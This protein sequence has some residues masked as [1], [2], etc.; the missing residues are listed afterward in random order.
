MSESLPAVFPAAASYS[1][2]PE[3]NI[4]FKYSMVAKERNSEFGG[5]ADKEADGRT[6]AEQGGHPALK[7]AGCPP[8]ICRT[9]HLSS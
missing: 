2:G 9:G 1:S 6:K 8:F 3:L 7:T 5:F 4:F